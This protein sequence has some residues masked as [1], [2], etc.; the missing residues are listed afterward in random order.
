MKPVF[1]GYRLLQTFIYI[2]SSLPKLPLLSTL[3]C[4]RQKSQQRQ[5][6]LVVCRYSIDTQ[7]WFTLLIYLHG[8][9]LTRGGSHV[10]PDGI[11][12]GQ[13]LSTHKTIRKNSCS[14]E[15]LQL[16]YISGRYLSLGLLLEMI[17]LCVWDNIST[18]Y[19]FMHHT[20]Q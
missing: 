4:S 18:R 10:E 2:S 13:T 1:F 16:W 5:V 14:G 9:F 8:L 12:Y 17:F 11:Q 20:A 6:L 15:F 3:L 7:A 19:W